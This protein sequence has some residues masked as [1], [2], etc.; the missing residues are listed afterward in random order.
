MSI[1]EFE[2][3]LAISIQSAYYWTSACRTHK[4]NQVILIL[5]LFF[6]ARYLPNG[7]R[8]LEFMMMSWYSVDFNFWENLQDLKVGQIRNLIWHHSS[9]LIIINVS[10]DH[11]V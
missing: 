1:L 4:D 5:S 2:L 7:K 3:A 11:N 8:E 10:A 9:Q 6:L